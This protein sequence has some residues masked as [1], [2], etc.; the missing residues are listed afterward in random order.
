MNESLQIKKCLQLVE[1]KL[2]WKPSNEWTDADYRRLSAI[3]HD[4]SGISISHQTLKRLF[5]KVNYKDYYNPQQA[6]KDALAKFLNYK[7]WDDF[8][9][10]P[11]EVKK[12]KT[13]FKNNLV[14]QKPGTTFDNLWKIVLAL[15]VVSISLFLIINNYNR[16][17]YKFSVKNPTGII[18]H[19]IEF[20]YDISNLKEDSV[21]LDC[22]YVH[23]VLA[24][25]KILLDKNKQSIRHCFQIP[26]CYTVRLI[27][28]KTVLA[29]TQ[30]QVCSQGW[31]TMFKGMNTSNESL[32]IKA[33]KVF[34]YGLDDFI[35]DT[36][37]D[38]FLYFSPK[39][40]LDHGMESRKVYYLESRNIQHY[41][42]VADDCELEIRFKNDPAEGGIS[43]FDSK[44][45]ILGKKGSTDVV[46]M[47]KGCSR[48]SRIN[49]SEVT[50]DGE[51]NDMTALSRD[52]SNWSTLK[53]V[54]K[55]QLATIFIDDK[56][57]YTCPYTQPMDS[58]KG[59]VLFF[60][61]SAKVDYIK[62][63]NEHKSIV[64]ADNFD[65]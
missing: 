55:N 35:N 13:R 21:Y 5:G 22:G 20:D 26:N 60:K 40:L 19:T 24:Y 56:C 47:Q 58:I 50:K 29:E 34:Q 27:A 52:L 44:F 30:V 7:D 17:E 46:F 65:N 1:Y 3:I 9:Q 28:E 2:Q 23:P 11:V 8:I 61:G 25:Q 51:Y 4:N 45:S 63:M 37:N 15:T 32:N 41:N 53:V 18:P 12:Q 39:T 14:K 16:S 10:N 64:F 31:I 62:L 43:C 54:N 6:T 49:V 33:E 42:A 57:I 36:V 48:W 59:L 38:G